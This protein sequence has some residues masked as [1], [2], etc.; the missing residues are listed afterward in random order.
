MKRRKA[1]E[2]ALKILY[3]YE[4]RQEN[5]EMI[6]DEFWKESPEKNEEIK[7]FATIL[8]KGAVSNIKIID[9]K[10]SE[11]ALNW[12]IERMSTIDRN[13]LRIGSFE[14]MFLPEIPP[15]VSINEAIELAKKYGTEDSP[16][17]VNGILHKIKEKTEQEGK[18]G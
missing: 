17:F 12:Q 5:I 6:I 18:N 4:M 15:A 10:I 9:K 7:E 2:C 3:M 11:V 13:I 16:K 8:A 14:I 1:R